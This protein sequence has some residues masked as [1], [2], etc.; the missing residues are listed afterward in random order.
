VVES[1]ECQFTWGGIVQSLAIHPYAA[2]LSV[3]TSAESVKKLSSI[4]NIGLN[5][6]TPLE[7]YSV[8]LEKG[9]GRFSKTM[10]KKLYFSNN[11]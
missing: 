1:G 9:V 7:S 3:G 2:S 4:P 8:P 10:L 11:L 6:P 5:P